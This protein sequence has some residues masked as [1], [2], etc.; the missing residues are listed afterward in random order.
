MSLLWCDGG[1]WRAATARIS[2]LLNNSV[3]LNPSPPNC[4]EW[5]ASPV[6]EMLIHICAWLLPAII[7]LIS[8]PF[9]TG[10][11]ALVRRNPLPVPTGGLTCACPTYHVLIRACVS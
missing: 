3:L 9:V 4:S 2:V 11:L 7:K 6:D 8:H 5:A 1:C 10:A